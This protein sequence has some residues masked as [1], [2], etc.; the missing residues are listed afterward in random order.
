MS[1]KKDWQYAIEG[2]KKETMDGMQEYFEKIML[3]LDEKEASIK[4]AMK[5]GNERSGRGQKTN[6]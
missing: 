4:D 6:R 5:A 1:S 3:N 2:V